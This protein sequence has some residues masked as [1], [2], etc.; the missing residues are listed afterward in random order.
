MEAAQPLLKPGPGSTG[1]SIGPPGG[2]FA[3][4]EGAIT[5]DY[6][7]NLIMEK[8]RNDSREDEMKNEQDSHH[9]KHEQQGNVGPPMSVP[10]MNLPGGSAG[11]PAAASVVHGHPGNFGGLASRIAAVQQA[12]AAA[13]AAQAQRDERDHGQHSDHRGGDSQVVSD[14]KYAGI[15]GA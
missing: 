13:A 7:N 11:H 2:V 15:N 10:N 12:A 1:P 3:R 14:K 6:F 5:I 8:M 4:R 9:N